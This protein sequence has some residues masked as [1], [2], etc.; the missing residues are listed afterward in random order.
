MPRQSFSTLITMP[1]AHAKFEVAQPFLLPS[2]AFL[3]LISY[4]M[5]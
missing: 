2:L 5:V 4:V 1:N 3:L